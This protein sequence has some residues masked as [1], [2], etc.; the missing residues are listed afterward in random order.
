MTTTWPAIIS[1][2]SSFQLS[3]DILQGSGDI[4][5]VVW[6][7]CKLQPCMPAPV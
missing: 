5:L 4:Y 1:H 6:K 3:F 2:K 7:I